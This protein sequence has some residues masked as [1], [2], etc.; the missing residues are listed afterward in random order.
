MDATRPSRPSTLFSLP[1]HHHVLLSLD[2]RRQRGSLPLA[3]C[4]PS[5]VSTPPLL[6]RATQSAPQRIKLPC[7][8]EKCTRDS[9]P[10][11]PIRCAPSLLVLFFDPDASPADLRRGGE[12]IWLQR[13][14]HRGT[15]AARPPSPLAHCL[16][17]P[18]RVWIARTIS[19]CRV[20]RKTPLVIRCRRGR[21]NASQVPSR[22]LLHR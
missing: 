5:P 18:I 12:D 21:G 1:I 6:T 7:G 4:V 17:A 14:L 20:L 19:Q 8:P 3:R 9:T 15:C 16:L 2:I 10:H 22:G 11:L 13:P